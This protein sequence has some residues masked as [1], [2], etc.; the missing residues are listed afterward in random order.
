[1]RVAIVQ[2]DPILGDIE[3]NKEKIRVILGDIEYDMII[4]PEMGI[5]GYGPDYVQ[6]G[7][8]VEKTRTFLEEFNTKYYICGA[9]K[10]NRNGTATNVMITNFTDNVVKH[11]LFR[12]DTG[13]TPGG[14]WYNTFRLEGFGTICLSICNDFNNK[15]LTKRVV[16]EN[17]DYM[18]VIGCIDREGRG[19]EYGYLKQINHWASS[20]DGY[21]GKFIACNIVGGNFIGG[22]CIFEIKDNPKFFKKTQ[23]NYYGRNLQE[24]WST[25]KT[26]FDSLKIRCLGN[27]PGR[28]LVELREPEEP[29][30]IE[31]TETVRIR[32]LGRQKE[33]YPEYATYDAYWEDKTDISPEDLAK[34][35][36]ISP[37]HAFKFFEEHPNRI[38]NE[39]AFAQIS[40]IEIMRELVP[41]IK[42][43]YGEDPENYHPD[44]GDDD[45]LLQFVMDAVVNRDYDR[46]KVF[47]ELTPMDW[48]YFG[49]T[50]MPIPE[51]VAVLRYLRDS[52]MEVPTLDEVEEYLELAEEITDPDIE[53]LIEIYG[54]EISGKFREV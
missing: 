22:S 41:I 39:G 37:D 46:I 10:I 21:R 42:E 43:H 18:I 9:L 47:S 25:V 54:E 31:D 13:I 32:E 2:Y 51:L 19:N 23:S 35:F 6:Y 17:P 15:E 3:G 27:L 52:G 30:D 48:S 28:I 8:T 5:L 1:M 16:E 12:D 34:A 38:R 49:S 29:E 26:T 4:L 45:I 14:E 40:D 20:L 53:G 50:P 33:F 11:K 36:D 7:D 44:A 24:V